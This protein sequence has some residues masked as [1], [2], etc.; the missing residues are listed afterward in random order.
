MC[1][2]GSIVRE[3]FA[4]DRI[5][6]L[7]VRESMNVPLQ[8][9]RSDEFLSGVGSNFENSCFTNGSNTSEQR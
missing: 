8:I 6:Y 1:E 5:D 9:T 3:R 7:L 4:T 2:L